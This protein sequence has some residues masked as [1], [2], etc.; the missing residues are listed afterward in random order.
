MKQ[1]NSIFVLLLVIFS[2]PLYCNKLRQTKQITNTTRTEKQN[3]NESSTESEEKENLKFQ[4]TNGLYYAYGQ[5]TSENCPGICRTEYVCECPSGWAQGTNVEVSSRKQSCG[6]KLKHQA[7][8]FALEFFLV[9]GVG[10]FYSGRIAY[11][12]IKLSVFLSVILFDIFI[13]KVTKIKSS[14]TRRCIDVFVYLLY[15]GL[16]IWQTFDVVMIGTNKFKDGNGFSFTTFDNSN[17]I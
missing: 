5:C 17:K 15:L 12:I 13:R 1:T 10:H 7:V 6:Y 16:L 8:V 11:A 9:L 3:S 4:S 2:I 14:K